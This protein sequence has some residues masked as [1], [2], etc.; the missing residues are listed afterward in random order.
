M[1]ISED[2]IW[3]APSFNERI[4]FLLIGEMIIT[5]P[6]PLIVRMEVFGVIMKVFGI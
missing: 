2:A 1:D 4:L 3:V 6:F 5:H